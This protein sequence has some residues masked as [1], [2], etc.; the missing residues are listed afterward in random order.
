MN[1]KGKKAVVTGGGRGIGAAVARALAAE[2]AAVVISARSTAEIEDLAVELRKSG[3]QA[4]A[5]PCDVTDPEQV[6]ALAREAR[7]R[8]GQVDIL[9]NNA[10]IAA[11]APL[12]RIRLDHWNRIFAVNATGTFL[13]TQAFLPDMVQRRWGRVV[14]VASIAG[15]SGAAYISAYAASKHAVVGF[16]RCIAAEVAPSGVTVNAV[17]PGYVETDMVTESVARIVEKTGLSEEEARGSI[18][19]MNPQDRILD[20]EEVAYQVVCLCDPRARGVNGQ[21]IVIDGGGLLS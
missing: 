1:L 6:S 11:S 17:C 15:L 16:T 20:P 4:W 21:T 7:E 10:G 5:A 8:L 13:C 12:K 2:G 14:N 9:V 19:K 18:L 3:G